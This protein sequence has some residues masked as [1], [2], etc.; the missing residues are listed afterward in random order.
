MQKKQIK[1]KIHQL[2]KDLIT[3]LD[4]N[5]NLDPWSKLWYEHIIATFENTC[6]RVFELSK[7]KMQIFDTSLE[8]R[9]FWLKIMDTVESSLW[10]TNIASRSSFGSNLNNLL[11][12]QKDTIDR[13]VSIQRIFVYDHSKPEEWQQLITIMTSQIFYGIEVYTIEVNVFEHNIKR[14]GIKSNTED[15]MVLDDRFVY[16][17]NYVFES[18][19]YRNA[20]IKEAQ[21]VKKMI[22]LK[23]DIMQDVR[24]VTLENISEFP[25]II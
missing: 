7:H 13:K 15:F 21:I 17:N 11:K 16:E 25:N 12:K 8:A 22:L 9:P 4:K 19:A 3:A 10:T 2:E 18:N 1:E 24:R 23:S 20:L 14:R 5:K 6:S